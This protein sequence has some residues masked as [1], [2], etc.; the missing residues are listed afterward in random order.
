M[1]KSGKSSPAQGTDYAGPPAE[2]FSQAMEG[3]TPLPPHGRVLLP[4]DLP[5]PLPRSFLE[6]EIAAARSALQDPLRWDE[7]TEMDAEASYVRAGIPRLVLRDLRRG[8]WIIQAELDL[9][10]LTRAEAKHELVGFL[11]DCKRRRVRCIR[12]IHGK[13][14]GSKN[15]EPVLR[16]HVRHWLKQREEILAYVEARAVDGGSGAVVVLLKSASR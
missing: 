10:G 3:V 7:E 11:H 13:G 2:E 9:H 5:P 8:G 15:R 4:A 12:I 16:Q 6:D 14:L 1:K